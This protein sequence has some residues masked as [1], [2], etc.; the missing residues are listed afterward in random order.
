[1]DKQRILLVEDDAQFRQHF[2]QALE[3]AL[4]AEPLDVTFVEVGSLTEARARLREGGLDAALIDLGCPTGIGWTSLGGTQ[5][6][7]LHASE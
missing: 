1:M 7:F 2:A 5:N 4:A 3:R 6:H